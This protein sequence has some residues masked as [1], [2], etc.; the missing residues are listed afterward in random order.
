MAGPFRFMPISPKAFLMEVIPWAD[1]PLKLERSGQAHATGCCAVTWIQRIEPAKWL[2]LIGASVD[3]SLGDLICRIPSC[4]IGR[5]A[6]GP[7]FARGATAE[8]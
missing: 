2:P 3:Q 5:K 7:T 1:Q 4:R 8:R 6:G